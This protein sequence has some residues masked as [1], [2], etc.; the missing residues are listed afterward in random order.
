M[1]ERRRDQRDYHDEDNKRAVVHDLCAGAVFD[2]AL[3]RT[4]EEGARLSTV[5]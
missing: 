2:K 3:A 1:D 4:E 5:H